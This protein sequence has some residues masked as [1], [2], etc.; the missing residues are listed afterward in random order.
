MSGEFFRTVTP[1]RRTSSGSR[2]SAIGDAVLHE[3]LRDV[4]I[5][6]EREGDG[7]LQLAVAGRLRGHVEHVLDAVDLLLDR[8]RDR[9]G[10]DLGGGARDSSRVMIDRSAARSPGYCA[11][12]RVK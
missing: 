8:R 4:E 9:V 10:D 12:G 6:A 7:D 2:G 3:H 5:G 11:T 1:M